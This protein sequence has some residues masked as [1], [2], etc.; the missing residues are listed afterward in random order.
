MRLLKL[1]ATYEHT[2]W[3]SSCSIEEP[4]RLLKLVATLTCLL[5][6]GTAFSFGLTW[7]ALDDSH[8]ATFRETLPILLP[9]LAV[10]TLFM[11]ALQIYW[12][13]KEVN[14]GETPL[15]ARHSFLDHRRHR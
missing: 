8:L 12:Y 7:W 10:F 1:V 5:A 6:E 11:C 13:R 15:V 14:P 9:M 4:M 3:W 2:K